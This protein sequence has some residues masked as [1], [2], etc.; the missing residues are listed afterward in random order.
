MAIK[1]IEQRAP[2]LG[3]IRVVD[4]VTSSNLALGRSVE[5]FGGIMRDMGFEGMKNKSLNEAKKMAD[6]VVLRNQ[7]GTIR[8]PALPQDDGVFGPTMVEEQYTKQL[9]DNYRNVV[10][11]DGRSYLNELHGKF[12]YDPAGYDASAGT[13]IEMMA[14]SAPDKWKREIHDLLQDVRIQH[15]NSI[16]LDRANRDFTEARTVHYE[17]MGDI[18]NEMNRLHTKRYGWDSPEMQLQLGMY[19]AMREE[20]INNQYFGENEAKAQLI[21][22][23]EAFAI[24]IIKGKL[25]ALGSGAIA[26]AERAKLIGQVAAGNATFEVPTWDDNGQMVIKERKASQ[27]FDP[28]TLRQ[29]STEMLRNE[30]IY[31]NIIKT[32]IQVMSDEFARGIRDSIANMYLDA[33]TLG[34]GEEFNIEQVKEIREQAHNF[35]AIL[36]GKDVARKEQLLSEIVNFTLDSEYKTM[37]QFRAMNEV[38]RTLANMAEID[39]MTFQRIKDLVKSVPGMEQYFQHI[40][41]QESSKDWAENVRPDQAM[42]RNYDQSRNYLQALNRYSSGRSNKFDEYYNAWDKWFAQ[43][44][45]VFQAYRKH[46]GI[47]EG[48]VN[49]AMIRAASQQFTMPAFKPNRLSTEFLDMKYQQVYQAAT[50]GQELVWNDMSEEPAVI[51]HLLNTYSAFGVA[52][53]GMLDQMTGAFRGDFTNAPAQVLRGLAYFEEMQ[54]NPAYM[55]H[56]DKEAMLGS[57]VYN[58]YSYLHKTGGDLNNADTQ[59]MLRKILAGETIVEF[60]DLPKERK[61]NIRGRVNKLL[62]EKTE[63]DGVNI[64]YEIQENVYY[65]ATLNA[66]KYPWDD[67]KAADAGFQDALAAGDWALTETGYNHTAKGIDTVS[68]SENVQVYSQYPPEFFVSRD[69]LDQQYVSGTLWG[70]TKTQLDLDIDS[71]MHT[72]FNAWANQVIRKDSADKIALGKNARLEFFSV[73]PQGYPIYRVMQKSQL[74]DWIPARANDKWY[75]SNNQRLEPFFDLA[76]FYP[77]WKTKQI[78]AM[79]QRRD[80]QIIESERRAKRASE[81]LFP[82]EFMR[83]Q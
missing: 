60:D 81:V 12:P 18:T 19:Y 73:G 25:S 50:G 36:E 65:H 47:A 80:E 31:Q 78:E 59:A 70:R 7:D 48:V 75:T 35:I 32:E 49:E 61:A 30:S 69:I 27:L 5:R 6:A 67:D 8:R 16:Q 83:A 53:R 43:A 20:G 3:T 45:P 62:E 52:P 2:T 21:K 26:E 1:R 74:G 63:I 24:S 54:K 13:Y 22:D 56:L 64:P 41:K 57:D 66:S 9:L 10:L 34:P 55:T 28:V 14:G 39:Q 23:Q 46:H 44:E 82:E 71:P 4:P 68:S 37:R 77:D 51:N 76:D 38:Q 42:P 15:S 79:E 17:M 11:Q 29:V 40:T 72:D 33:S 58:A